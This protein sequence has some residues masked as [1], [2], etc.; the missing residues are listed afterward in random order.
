M[1]HLYLCAL[2]AT[3]LLATACSKDGGSETPT[4]EPAPDKTQVTF[5]YN[6]IG[7]FELS[8]MINGPG[9]YA[10]ISN[11]VSGRAFTYELVGSNGLEKATDTLVKGSGKL[12]ASG[13]ATLGLNG[14]IR[15]RDG[16][17]TLKVTLSGPDTTIQVK[18]EK[19]EYKIRDYRDFINMY[20][21]RN[22]DASDHYVQVQDFAFPDTMF[23]RAPCFRS[24]KGTYDGQGHKI[25]NLKINA[26]HKENQ[27]SYIG[28]FA[29]ADS[30]STI[31]NIRLELAPEGFAGVEGQYG[32][33][34]GFSWHAN[35]IACS[36][37][38][39]IVVDKS[40]F[41]YAGGISGFNYNTNMT[42][43]SFRG[44]LKASNVGGL[45]GSFGGCNINM[46]YAYFSFDAYGAGG[47]AGVPAGDGHISNS[48]AIVHDYNADVSRFLSM[49]PLTPT[50]TTI[51]T[52]CFATAG[53]PEPGV[54]MA[55]NISE[56]GIQAATLEVVEWPAGTTA[57]AGKRPFRLDT[58]FDH[59]LKLWW[60]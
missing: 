46:C 34:V 25:T 4:P 29:D 12:N 47:L 6:Q 17:M 39:D 11:G 58:D 60:E 28:L 3:M 41:S 14:L 10:T 21:M 16:E 45:M 23:N 31:K 57:P 53:T 43:C 32:G 49:G 38:G 59:P 27:S 48:Y 2:T 56:L 5:N 50:S 44:H 51:I 30:G 40:V 35:I 33:I 7:A 20:A 42:G 36:V 24:L 19:A 15:Y 52:N 1:T 26:P 13:G 37:K 9:I 18:T 8:T 54:R 22:P 55:T